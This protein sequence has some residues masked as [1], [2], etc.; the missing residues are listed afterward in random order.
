ME[1]HHKTQYQLTG[2]QYKVG[3]AVQYQVRKNGYWVNNDVGIVKRIGKRVS[4][5]TRSGVVKHLSDHGIY[6]VEFTG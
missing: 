6:Q 3:D 2:N 1:L 5:E 4:V